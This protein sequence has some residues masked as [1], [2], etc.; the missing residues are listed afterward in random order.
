MNIT[1]NNWLMRCTPKIDCNFAT[2]TY[3]YACRL[4]EN[5][6]GQGF[7]QIG[8]FELRDGASRIIC[9]GPLRI[10]E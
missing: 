6:M 2:S 8:R 9:D 3:R 1:G 5:T 10:A 7:W 4:S